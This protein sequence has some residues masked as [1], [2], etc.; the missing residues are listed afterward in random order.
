LWPF[1]VLAGP[2]TVNYKDLEKADIVQP[3]NR[4]L[5]RLIAQNA[6]FYYLHHGDVRLRVMLAQTPQKDPRG[7]IIFN[8]GRTEFIE[9]YFET[10]ENFLALGFNVLIF[11]PRGQGLSDRLLPDPLKCYVRNFQDYATDLGFIIERF[12]NDLP[13]PHMLMGHSMGGCVVLL[14]VLT[15][16]VNPSAVICSAP[17]LGLFDVETRTTEYFIRV[18]NILGFS[19]KNLPFQKQDRGMP[20]PFEGN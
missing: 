6:S 3:D 8:P 19:K 13:K 4:P 14:S 9:K 11:D 16:V 17:M 12:K 15:G 18:F 1:H 10:V 20:V 5:P 7:S 2:V